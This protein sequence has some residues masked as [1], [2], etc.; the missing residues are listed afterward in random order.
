MGNVR[1]DL[2]AVRVKAL[3]NETGAG[4]VRSA[5]GGGGGAGEL[6]V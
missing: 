2:E 6:Q 3:A 1:V 5:G 4:G